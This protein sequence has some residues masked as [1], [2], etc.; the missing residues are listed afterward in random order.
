[1]CPSLHGHPRGGALHPR[2]GPA[3]VRDG[4]RRRRSPTAGAR[5]R[6]ATHS[7]C[8]W[9]ARAASP[10]ARSASTWP[11]TRPS[12]S[13][14]TTGPAAS[15]VALLD[16]LAARCCAQLAGRLP[17]LVNAVS[18]PAAD[19]RRLLKRPA[20]SRRSA[21]PAV[22]PRA[23]HPVVERRRQ[24]PRPPGRRPAG[25]VLLWPDTFTNHFHPEVG[26]AA[27]PVLEDAGFE[28]RVPHA[29]GL[30]RPDLDLHRPARR[31]RRGPAPHGRGRCATD[32]APA[33]R[34]SGWSRRC[35]AVFRSD[36]PSCSTATRTCPA[37]GQ[38]DQ[39]PGRAARRAGPDWHPAAARRRRP[40]PDPLPP[41]RRPR[42]RRRRR[43][44][45]GRR[46]RRRPAR[47]RLLRAGRELRLRDA[48]TTRCPGGAANGL[49][50]AVRDAARHRRARRRVQLPHPDPRG[51][52]SAGRGSTWRN[53]WPGCWKAHDDQGPALSGPRRAF[54]GVVRGKSA[55]RTDRTGGSPMAIWGHRDSEPPAEEAHETS[56]PADPDLSEAPAGRE[57]QGG[58]FRRRA[59]TG[60]LAGAGRR[61]GRG[62]AGTGR[63][64]AAG[65]R[66]CAARGHGAG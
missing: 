19:S 44:A 50:P 62:R 40:R 11:P 54:E 21:P 43:A 22:R 56:P 29:A 59:G 60:V 15:G 5:P 9:P 36:G 32:S 20:A 31:R 2:P 46:R 3:A 58:G 38:A 61:A 7:T 45:E 33:S 48:A 10:T 16:G 63:R 64:S 14:T 4:A 42:Q 24:A 57:D 53:C 47:L 8:A 41:A 13:P 30:L 18:Q 28:V 1:M 35:T 17:G 37:A 65:I 52:I 23:L 27:V 55:C 12:S 49:W 66:P 34:S 51:P 6:S 26:R 39:H 25:T